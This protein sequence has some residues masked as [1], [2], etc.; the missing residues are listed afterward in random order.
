MSNTEHPADRARP[1]GF[2]LVELLVVV[3]ILGALTALLI[4]TLAGARQA[5]LRAICAAN[6]R[7]VHVAMTMYLHDNRDQFPCA[8]D[9]VS[10]SP[11]Y[12]LW[13]GRGW[14]RPM[15]KYFS[16]II[17]QQNPSLLVC[18]GDPAS[19]SRYES[20]S[21]SYSMSFYYSPA[22]IDSLNN[23]AQTYSNP[24]PFTAQ[25]LGGVRHPDGKIMIGEWTSNHPVIAGDGGWWCWQGRRNY[26]LVDG[27]IR[28]LEARQI[29]A[30][31]DGWPDA[32]LTIGGLGG[33]DIVP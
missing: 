20:T 31:R 10:T 1:Q 9:P 28:D 19:P 3:A 22:Q 8:Q 25:Q 6:L 4:P 24:Q 23:A 16:T 14:R 13:M 2:T 5:S 29:L 7:Q 17:T 26:L 15:Q 21:Y 27:Q 33:Y 30:A 32:N 12:W 11:M 18:K